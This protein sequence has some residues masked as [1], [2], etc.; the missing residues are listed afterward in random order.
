MFRKILVPLD[1]SEEARAALP[2]AVD[3]ARHFGGTVLLLEMVRTGDATLGLA[4]DV[5]SG[6]LTD[7]S[8]FSA[9]V[10]ARQTVA[11]GYIA[12]VADELHEQGI[13]VAYAV[14]TGSEGAGIVEAARREAVD[15]IVMA[16]HARGGLGRL[17]FG[18]VTDHVIRHAHV[19]VLAIPPQR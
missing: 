15:L 5:A 1:D 2:V 9:E 19:P 11:E 10:A 4:A 6:A 16:T 7:P 12:A 8:V 3:L 18:S 13:D 14:G 17:V